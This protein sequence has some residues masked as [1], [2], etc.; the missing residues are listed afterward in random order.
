VDGRKNYTGPRTDAELN[1]LEAMS[2]NEETNVDPR[3]PKL[4]EEELRKRTPN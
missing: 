1:I 3:H 4:I 2:T